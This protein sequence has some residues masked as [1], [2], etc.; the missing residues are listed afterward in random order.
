VVSLGGPD[1]LGAG[2]SVAVGI[3]NRVVVVIGT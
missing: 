3:G 1:V 2:R